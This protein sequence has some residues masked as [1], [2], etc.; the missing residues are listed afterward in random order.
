MMSQNLLYEQV[1]DLVAFR[2]IVDS[3]RECYEALGVVHGHWK[4]VPGR[5]KDYVALPKANGSQSL[6]TAVDG[7][8]AL[9]LIHGSTWSTSL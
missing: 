2:V 4:P 9:P 5:F 1:Y 7:P 8:R 6:H 3:M